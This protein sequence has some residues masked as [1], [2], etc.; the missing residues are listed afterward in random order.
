M[1]MQRMMIPTGKPRRF[2]APAPA[3]NGGE[4]NTNWRPLVT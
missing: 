3:A 2:A 4:P 1:V